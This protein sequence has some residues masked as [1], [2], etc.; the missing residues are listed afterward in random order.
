M[1]RATARAAVDV[2]KDAWVLVARAC[3][4]T[5]ETTNNDELRIQC[6]KYLS[7]AH[8]LI[9][10]AADAVDTNWTQGAACDL[11]HAT[12]LL[13]ETLHNVNLGPAANDVRATIEDA[14]SL[15]NQSSGYSC[16]AADGG[17][18]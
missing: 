6:A 2:A 5:A 10:S 9:Q 4:D 8:N 15:A 11:A 3:I 13:V 17:R 1:P 14:V 16:G 12:D 18:E 7:P